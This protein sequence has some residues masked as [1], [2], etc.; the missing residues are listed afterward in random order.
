MGKKHEETAAKRVQAQWLNM[1]FYTHVFLGR[2]PGCAK[3]C[4]QT[5]VY[6]FLTMLHTCTTSEWC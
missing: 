6:I 5:A 1:Q 3:Q 4:S 2:G